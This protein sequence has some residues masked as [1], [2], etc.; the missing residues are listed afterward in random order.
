MGK[1]GMDAL[2]LF[3]RKISIAGYFVAVITLFTRIG[4]FMSL[5]FLSIYLTKENLFSPSKIGI[6]IGVSGLIFCLFGLINGALI[7]RYGSKILLVISLILAGFCY[8]ALALNIRLFMA[9]VLVNGILGWL[10]S[11]IDISSMSV[12]VNNTPD[13]HLAA[14]YS[15]RFIALNL[16]LVLGPVIGAAF[17]GNK[18]LFI[19][20]L[21]VSSIF[22]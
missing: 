20:I 18:S 21:L 2:M 22:R 1:S 7:D 19:F 6:I 11:I 4:F 9:L 17:A 5:Q 14:V 12:A 15:A 13:E 8:F 16:G 3:F 10:R